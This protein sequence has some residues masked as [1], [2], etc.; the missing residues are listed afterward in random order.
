MSRYDRLRARRDAVRAA[1]ASGQVADSMEVRMALMARV[2][3]GEITLEQAQTELK[4]IKRGA[5]AAG[6]T[7]RAK[8]FR[9]GS[10]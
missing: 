3:T 7:T 9:E 1:E 8:A 4:K 2:D 10:L 5:K 6:Q